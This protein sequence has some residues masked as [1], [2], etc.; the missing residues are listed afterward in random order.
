M[1]QNPF[2][3][4]STDPN[5]YPQLP[6]SL[7]QAAYLDARGGAVMAK[8]DSVHTSSM[9][10]VSHDTE[11]SPS[12][13]SKSRK[14]DRRTPKSK[15]EVSERM[16]R[17]RSENAEKNRLN[18]LRCRVYR[19][20]RIRFGKEPTPER[21]AWIQSEIFRRLERRRLREAMKGNGS[22]PAPTAIT[23]PAS[24]G[25]C[26]TPTGPMTRS[27]STVHPF[28]IHMSSNGGGVPDHPMGFPASP[29]SMMTGNG[30]YGQ[31]Q[32]GHQ[33]GD[34]MHHPSQHGHPGFATH[35]QHLSHQHQSQPPNGG[36]GHPGLGHIQ[37]H[38]P[39]PQ[40]GHQ[41]P[42]AGDGQLPHEF[43]P[44]APGAM[45]PT[46]IY[47][48]FKFIN[49]L[50]SGRLLSTQN[51]ASSYPEQQQ[52]QH[53]PSQHQHQYATPHHSSQPQPLPQMTTS[54]VQAPGGMTAHSVPSHQPLTDQQPAGSSNMVAAAAAAAAAVADFSGSFQLPQGSSQSMYPYYQDSVPGFGTSASS[55]EL[56][57]GQSHSSPATPT[58][59][60]AS[61]AQPQ[62]T[63]HAGADSVG[64]SAGTTDTASAAAPAANP[65]SAFTSLSMVDPI[66]NSALGPHATLSTGGADNESSRPSADPS[67]SAMAAG[68]LSTTSPSLN[69]VATNLFSLRQIGNSAQP[70]AASETQTDSALS[71]QQTSSS[72]PSAPTDGLAA[73]AAAAAV[74]QGSHVADTNGDA[75]QQ[76]QAHHLRHNNMHSFNLGM[77]SDNMQFP[78][79][80]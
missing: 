28:P 76:Q 43:M 40:H 80:S 52:Q 57:N 54:Q 2:A 41:Q 24:M 25:M 6:D 29:Y 27:R 56:S 71:Q 47:N 79:Y 31:G 30:M 75:Q 35:H 26:H 58:G 64:Y 12:T 20:A 55:G 44:A 63:L 60:A 62:Y 3:F 32:P 67:A 42:S 7:N 61:S 68:A 18:D 34:G 72:Q 78:N 66:S 9:S 11:S 36:F 53:Q 38:H 1:N 10:H 49:P 17:W 73:V 5:G 39:E 21:E 77:V 23:N 74:S 65:T 33:Y 59:G 19:Q 15:A 14:S 69:D 22:V 13:P 8:D 51:A 45:P 4:F 50:Y 16:R 48:S 70:A 46:D 37:H